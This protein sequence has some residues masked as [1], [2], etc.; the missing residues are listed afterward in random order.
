MALDRITPDKE[1]L[2]G[3]QK[4]LPWFNAEALAQKWLKRQM[5]A[6]Y[7][8]S[9]TEQD[10]KAYQQVRNVYLYKLNR[11][12]CLYL[13]AAIED[14]QGD[15]WKLFGPLDSLS[16]EPGETQCLH[17]QPHHLQK[18]LQPSSRIKLKPYTNPSIQKD[19]LSVS[20]TFSNDLPRKISFKPVTLSN[21]RWLLTKAKPTTCLSDTIPTMLLKT[22]LEAFLPLI[23]KV[24]KLS[25]TFDTFPQPWKRAIVKPLLKKIS[26]ENN[27]K[28]YRQYV[29]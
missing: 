2:K 3:D 23:T 6:R 21:V 28:N 24:I 15:Q 4:R 9:H 26:L 10:K 12:T 18:A 1:S 11:A 8:K 5:E 29:A 16:K 14:T 22:H 25:L 19:N 20:S 27:F 7:V 13:N 17:A